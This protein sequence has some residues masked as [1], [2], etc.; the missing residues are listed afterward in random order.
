MQHWKKLLQNSITHPA[1]LPGHLVSDEELDAVVS[2]YPMRIN[3]Y[4]L[5][6]MNKKGDPLWNQAVPSLQE[7]NDTVCFEDPLNEENLSPVANVIH[8]YPDRVLFLVTSQCAMYCRFCTR[9]RKVGTDGMVITRETIRAGIDYIRQHPEIRD[10]LISGGDPLLLDDDMLEEIL[11]AVRAIPSVEIIRIGSRVPCTLPMRVT[12]KL[13]AMLKKYHPL[14]INTHFN[15]P[16][17]I[18]PESSLACK[19]LA[20]AGIPMGCQTVLLRGVNDDPV[21]IKEL[22]HKLLTIRVKPYYLFQTDMTRG[23][24]HFRTSIETGRDIMRSLIGHTSGLAVPLY[25][26]DAPGGGGKI[27]LMPDYINEEGQKIV[28]TNYCGKTCF[29]DNGI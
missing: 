16:C 1:Q 18:T 27:P 5:G 25:A 24:N 13:A 7:L 28:F 29:Y 14:Y 11:S 9:K 3:P 10:V 26:V 21:V 17:E 6:L 20:D 4:Y 8:K 23:T 12:V 2:R 19:R 22:M 15:H